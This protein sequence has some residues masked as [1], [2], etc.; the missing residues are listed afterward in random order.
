MQLTVQRRLAAYVG[1]CSPNRVKFSQEHLSEIKEAITKSDIRSLIKE[2]LIVIEPKQG[3]SRGRI[4][5]NKAQRRKGRQRGT[6]S[7][8]GTGN[9]RNHGK[10]AWISRIRLQRMVLRILLGRD[11]ISKDVYRDL[12]HKAGGG[13]FRSRRHILLY[14]EEHGLKKG[15]GSNA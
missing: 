10:T 11:V 5:H 15:K 4:R 13:F 8:K 14:I 7:R 3:T 6:G 1:N 2:G 12:Y 9:V